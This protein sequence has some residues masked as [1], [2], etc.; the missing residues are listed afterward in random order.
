MS[1]TPDDR[2]GSLAYREAMGI[3]AA[4]PVRRTPADAFALARDW[5][6]NGRQLD[7]VSLASELGISR[8]TLYR[9]TEDRDQLLAEVVW[10]DLDQIIDQS[11][12]A[13]AGRGVERLEAA[14]GRFLDFVVDQTAVRTLLANE[15]ESGLRM[16]IA[17]R[18]PIRPRLLA[19][20][21]SIIADEA[22]AGHYR[23]PASPEI[24]A[25]GVV[26]L[27]ERFLHNG[28]DPDLNPDLATAKTIVGLLLR[29]APPSGKGVNAA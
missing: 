23:P 3:S 2:E 15:G 18:G 26:S 13:A 1:P 29:E 17:P 12:A 21:S 28:G 25:D 4:P 11:W 16:L 7:M 8:G 19:R 5:V 14:V 20:V 6:R 27:G 10:A 24:I 22:E 9:W